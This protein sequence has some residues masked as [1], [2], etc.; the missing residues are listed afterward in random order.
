MKSIS[1][2]ENL[3]NIEAS[4]FF[5]CTNLKEFIIP[6]KNK[7]FIFEDGILF[8]GDKTRMIC[9]LSNAIDNNTFIIP[10]NVTQIESEIISYYSQIE[11]VEIPK[12][13]N[14][15]SVDAFGV[16]VNQ[17]IVDSQNE[18]YCSTEKALYNKDKTY[19][20]LYFAKDENVELEEGLVSIGYYAFKLNQQVKNIILPNS[21]EKINSQGFWGCNN[22][23]NIKIGRNIKYID[24]I[25][26]YG[27]DNLILEIDKENNY[28]TIENNLLFNK[29][30][31]T[32]ITMIGNP[33]SITIPYGVEVIGSRAFH[34][35]INLKNIIIPNTVKEISDSFNYCK[36]LTSIEIPS[37]VTKISTSCFNDT[38]NLKSII[39]HNEK[40]A[41]EGSP[42]G[43]IYGERAISYQP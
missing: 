36:S 35:K 8:N 43:C 20:V 40:G 11:R 16:N 42:W 34:N 6:E 23:K 29:E 25:A 12:S 2:T 9:V 14:S 15:I 18:T 5:Q 1:F 4:V 22:L 33:E 30:K 7:N 19:L 37:S 26:F 31:T 38:N 13:V 32:L 28:Y 10:D 39:I 41:I 17:I 24:P 3:E 27:L 21:L